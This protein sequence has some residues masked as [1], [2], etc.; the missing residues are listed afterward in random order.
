MVGF[1]DFEF[2]D[3][4]DGKPPLT[5]IPCR[6]YLQYDALEAL[7][8]CYHDAVFN[9]LSDFELDLQEQIV[10]RKDHNKDKD[11][12]AD[13]EDGWLDD[14]GLYW[15]NTPCV[16]QPSFS[17]TDARILY[18]RDYWDSELMEIY[19]IEACVS[20]HN[21]TFFLFA[22]CNQPGDSKVLEVVC[23]KMVT[24]EVI[25]DTVLGVWEKVSLGIEM[26]EDGDNQ[27]SDVELE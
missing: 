16:F 24:D 1:Q 12:V 6:A 15:E 9:E 14:C 25:E 18:Q 2:A 22:Y 17:H 23:R 10:E 8:T 4:L 27:D 26:E 21:H 5:K 11:E 20:D 13:D 3:D 7:F 19:Q